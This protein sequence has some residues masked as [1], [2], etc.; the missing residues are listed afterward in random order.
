MRENVRSQDQG[1]FT[2]NC[3][4]DADGQVCIAHIHRSTMYDIHIAS[5][6][7][8]QDQKLIHICQML[9]SLPCI[10]LLPGRMEGRVNALKDCVSLRARDPRRRAGESIYSAI[11]LP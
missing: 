4:V 2:L 9:I 8:T 3:V 6:L 5:I 10:I 11:R 7:H 1:R